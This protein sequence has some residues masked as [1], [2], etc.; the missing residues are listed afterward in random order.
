VLEYGSE[1]PDVFLHRWRWRPL[2][3]SWRA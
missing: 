3:K 1:A 2:M